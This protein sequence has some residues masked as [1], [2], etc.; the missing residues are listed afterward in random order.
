MVKSE[1]RYRYLSHGSSPPKKIK[2]EVAAKRSAHYE[3][4]LLTHNGYHI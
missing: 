1:T 2:Y 4:V 3:S